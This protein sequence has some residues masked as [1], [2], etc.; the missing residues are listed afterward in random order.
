MSPRGSSSLLNAAA[1]ETQLNSAS[2]KQTHLVSD[3][4]RAMKRQARQS[5]HNTDFQM[6]AWEHFKSNLSMNKG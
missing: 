1:L 6:K 2:L 4:G 5:Q 3:T